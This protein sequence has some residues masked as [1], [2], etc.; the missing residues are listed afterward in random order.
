MSTQINESVSVDLLSNHLTGKVFPWAVS[1]RGRRYQINKVGL[2]HM[3]REGRVLVHIFSVTDGTTYFKLAF[4]TVH[5][6]WQLLET[7]FDQ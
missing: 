2:H 6:T 1:W 5:L 3:V 4:N 7:S